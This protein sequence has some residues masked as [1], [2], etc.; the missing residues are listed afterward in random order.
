[1]E[2]LRPDDPDRIGPYRTLA[3]LD[4]SDGRQ[5][6][7]ERRYLASTE[8]GRAMMVVCLPGPG[9]DPVRWMIEA[10]GARR[11]SVPGFLPVAT[12]GGSAGAPWCATPYLP[13]LPLP[14]ALVAHGG[15]LPETVVRSWGA[16]IAE[17]LASAH[18][19]GVTH[20][21][22]A[23]AAVLLG[24]EGP[25]LSC[26]GAVRAAAPDGEQRSGQPGLD[27]GCLAPEQAHGGRPRPL[28]DVYALGAVLSYASTGHTVPEREELPPSL[29]DLVAACLSRDPARRPSAT[30]IHATLTSTRPGAE[31]APAPAGAAI[32]PA[33]APIATV[34]DAQPAAPAMLPARLVTALARQS[35]ELL[36]AE[37]PTPTALD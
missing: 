23:P 4:P 34:V 13:V 16:A 22:L 1:M 18:A 6:V 31:R 27:P 3:R 21:G 25:R 29:R 12:V 30:E 35:T 28:G 11:L 32:A 36:A 8:D 14:T 17:S 26:F 2:H 20:A 9:T 33:S 10:E 37:L 5:P 7:P 15:P 24:A 19:R